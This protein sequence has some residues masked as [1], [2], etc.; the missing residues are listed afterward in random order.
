MR[1]STCHNIEAVSPNEEIDSED[2]GDE[3]VEGTVGEKITAEKDEE[4][5]RQITDPRKPTQREVERHS[6]T[7]LPYRNWCYVCV[8]GRGRDLDHRKDVREDRGLP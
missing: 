1:C 7:H 4:R 6:L 8:A 3:M 2:E 5:V